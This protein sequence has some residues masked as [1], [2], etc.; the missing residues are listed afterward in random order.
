MTIKVVDKGKI[1]TFVCE[2]ILIDTHSE[3]Y[4]TICLFDGREFHFGK[5]TVI[6]AVCT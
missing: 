2:S 4:L 6:L 5:G 3:D 1:K